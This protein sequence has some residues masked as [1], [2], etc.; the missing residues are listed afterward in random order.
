[1]TK[2]TVLNQALSSELNG[3]QSG[4]G[5]FVQS[6]SPATSTVTLSSNYVQNYQKNGITGNEVGTKV[7][8]SGNTVIG[9]GSTT[10]AAEN[11]IQ[12]GFGATG[13]ISSNIVGDD[14]WAPDTSTDPGDAAAGILVFASSGI[15]ITGNTVNSTQFGIAIA[16]DSVDGT[17]DGNTIKT[18]KIG[19]THIFDGI[20][21]CSSSNLVT[22]NSVLGSDES[23]IHIDDSCTASNGNSVSGNTL[24]TACAGLLIGPTAAGNSITPN[25]FINVSSLTLTAAACAPPLASV[26]RRSRPRLHGFRP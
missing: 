23:A 15:T 6:G 4:L 9:Q 13:S 24:H 10:G 17:A 2:N 20:D 7:T 26:P 22:G 3:C 11:S 25:T 18:N 8:I 1:V 12:I 16:G 19:A 21:L 14:I 5:I